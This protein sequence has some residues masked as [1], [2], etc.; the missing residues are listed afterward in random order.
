MDRDRSTWDAI[1]VHREKNSMLQKKEGVI[2]KFGLLRDNVRMEY[3]L[4]ANALANA[5]NLDKINLTPNT[6]NEA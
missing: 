6:L 3:A 4:V 2:K 5:K 1:S